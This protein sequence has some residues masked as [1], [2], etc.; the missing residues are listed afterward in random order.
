MEHYIYNQCNTYKL[1]NG[2]KNFQKTSC[3]KHIINNNHIMVLYQPHCENT[4]IKGEENDESN[5]LYPITG[6]KILNSI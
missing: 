1:I 5:E 3:T 6:I 2:S 4:V